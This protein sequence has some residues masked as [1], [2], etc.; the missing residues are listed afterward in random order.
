MTSILSGKW[1]KWFLNSVFILAV[2]TAVCVA[3][4]E[5]GLVQ[6]FY[7]YYGCPD[8]THAV[9]DEQGIVWRPLD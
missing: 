3:A 2:I 7:D 9:L 8:G 4:V 6:Y 1:V 5:T